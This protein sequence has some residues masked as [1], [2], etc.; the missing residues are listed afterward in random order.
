[1]WSIDHIYTYVQDIYSDACTSGQHPS[2][3]ATN[4]QFFLRAYFNRDNKFRGLG[5][6]LLLI[7]LGAFLA[8][9]ILGAGS[10]EPT[11]KP[12]GAH[13]KRILFAK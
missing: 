11:R 8:L 2:F 4:L 9:A 12:L 13:Q 5:R 10:N 3:G 7:L 6:L 1:M